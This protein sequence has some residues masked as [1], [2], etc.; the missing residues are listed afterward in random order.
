MYKTEGYWYAIPK[1]KK[2]SFPK[3]KVLGNFHKYAHKT[4]N[5]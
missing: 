5:E 3:S 2:L 4:D 1:I